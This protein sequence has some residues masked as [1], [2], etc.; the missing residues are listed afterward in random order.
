LLRRRNSLATPEAVGG[1]ADFAIV[2]K[3]LPIREVQLHR[4]CETGISKKAK[5]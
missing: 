1:A 3:G 2:Q 5:S 4:F